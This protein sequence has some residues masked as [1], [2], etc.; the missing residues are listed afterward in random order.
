MF[1]GNVKAYFPFLKFLETELEQV[2][3]IF[4]MK[5]ED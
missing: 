4:L 1:Q 3:K 2:V 5:D